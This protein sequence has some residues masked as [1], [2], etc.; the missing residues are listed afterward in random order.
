MKNI[1][2]FNY[3]STNQSLLESASSEDFL[4]LE[5]LGRVNTEHTLNEGQLLDT[6]KNE[7]SKFFL[8]KFSKLSLIDKAREVLVELEIDLIEKRA[9]MEDAVE[10]IESK[11]DSIKFSDDRQKVIALRKDRD[12]K[13]KEFEEYEKF[14]GLKIK[15]ALDI[16][17]DAIKGDPRKKK[18]YEAGRAEDE[19]GLAE[20]Q[21]KMAKKR[22]DDT[23]IKKYEEELRKAKEEAEAKIGEIKSVLSK[24]KG[25]EGKSEIEPLKSKVDPEKE[26]K[27]VSSRK[28]RDIIE[29][30]R[31]LEKN[32][33]DLRA[34]M[35][36]HVNQ[37]EKHMKSGKKVS[38]SYVNDKKV[39]LLTMAADLDAQKNLLKILRNLG[40]TE[41]EITKKLSKESEFTKLTNMI[42]QG[43]S[44][45]KDSNSGLKKVISSIFVGPEGT[46]SAGG[47][48]KTKVKLNE[49]YDFEF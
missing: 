19:I 38:K 43:I 17:K 29:R 42:N 27:K 12:N 20:L 49:S 13:I 2:S 45:G 34:D 36:R 22:A 46:I 30:K 9:E 37:I 14:A 47:I 41:S 8:G 1:P 44:D 40:K 33:A 7:M 21:Y 11:I 32:I 16:V 25:S 24:E 3:F 4:K 39:R 6:I 23:E 5:Q 31:D 28:G 10:E 15:K 18:Y 26:K 48:N 35:E